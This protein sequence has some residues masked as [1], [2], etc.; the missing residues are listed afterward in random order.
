MKKVFLFII[1]LLPLAFTVSCLFLFAVI[2]HAQQTRQLN[3]GEQGKKVQLKAIWRSSWEYKTDPMTFGLLHDPV[4]RTAWDVSD[5]QFQQINTLLTSFATRAETRK[6][7]EDAEALDKLIDH[8]AANPDEETMQKFLE[9]SERSGVRNAKY[10]TEAVDL[11]LTPEQQQKIKESQ[12]ANMAELP[13]IFPSMFD[14]LAQTDAQRREMEQI[15]K[16]LEPELEE[17]LECMASAEIELRHQIGEIHSEQQEQN[18]TLTPADELSKKLKATDPVLKKLFEESQSR[19]KVFTTKFKIK[20]F[21]VLTD[22]QWDRFQKLVDD[23]PEHTKAFGK[24]LKEQRG[25]SEKSGEWAPGPN[26]W[27]PGDPIPEGYR[28]QRS[29][30]RFP[31]NVQSE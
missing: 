7:D 2:G 23:P 28:Q 22:E 16:E 6:I 12:L 17:I 24:K 25:E 18:K 11:T 30:G 21:D 20:M 31:R 19:N 27:K 10:I 15:K 1:A 3:F 13:I 26:S 8:S 14:A 9:L 29:E 4:I 5:E